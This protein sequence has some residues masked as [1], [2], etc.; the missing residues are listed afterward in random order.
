MSTVE[1][2]LLHK[3]TGRLGVG[4]RVS[5]Y[6]KVQDFPLKN[7]DG[8]SIRLSTEDY[9]GWLIDNES[10]IWIFVTKELAEKTLDFLGEL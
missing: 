3:E 7:M 8:Y 4:I 2:V 9:D 6:D 5:F 10:N 1:R